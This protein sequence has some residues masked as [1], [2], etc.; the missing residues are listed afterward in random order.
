MR[1]LI[2][3]DSSPGAEQALELAGSL[4]WSEDSEL[5]IVTVF[6]PAF[7]YMG[8]YVGSGSIPLEQI[9]ADMT[10]FHE[11][12]LSEAVTAL[13]S[14]GLTVEGV[15]LRGR[16]ATELLDEAQRWDADLVMGG[17]RGHGPILNLLLGSVSAEVVDDAPCPALISRTRTIRRVVFATDG[18]APSSLAETLL[19]TWP[20]FAG[21]PIQVVSVA[22]VVEPWHTGIAPTMYGQVL[23]A[24]A[25]DLAEAQAEHQ[26][27]ADETAARLRTAGR[28]AQGI[29]RDGDAAGEILAAV[30]ESDADLVVMGSRG[31]TGIARLVMGSVARNVLQSSTASVL[32]VHAPKDAEPRI[33]EGV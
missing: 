9:D 32:I 31:R 19:A 29:L 23:E 15:V 21:L 3:Y 28:D 6:E 18:S 25:R 30:A 27:I 12:R 14:T 33:G 26:R 24:H 1:V 20:I 4:R 2:A 17:S 8:P 16:P 11:E 22:D 7:V 5:R 10:A 13:R